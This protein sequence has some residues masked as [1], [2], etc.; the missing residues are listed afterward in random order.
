MSK[1]LKSLMM[2]QLAGRFDGIDGGLLVSTTGLNSEQTYAF[3]KML[4]GKGMRLTMLRNALARKTF[5]E[6]GYPSDELKSTLKGQLCMVY[7]HDEGSATAAAR[8]VTDWK[9][10][11]RDKI[12]QLQGALMDGSVMGPAEA[13]QLKDAPTRS[14]AYAMLAGA[15][16]APIAKLMGTL[17]E[18]PR[19]WIGVFDAYK[20]KQEEA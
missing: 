12:V 20:R 17:N 13:E 14:D 6:R 18:V 8:V 10:D 9:K 7:T 5:E 19:Q 3:R 16:Q 11:T 1:E 4:Q 2:D 15:L